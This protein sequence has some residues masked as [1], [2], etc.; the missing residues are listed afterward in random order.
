MKPIVCTAKISSMASKHILLAFGVNRTTRDAMKGEIHWGS[1]LVL[2]A[3]PFAVSRARQVFVHVSFLQ[4][5]IIAKPW[6]LSTKCSGVS[7]F[8]LFEGSAVLAWLTPCTKRKF[9]NMW[10][11]RN[12]VPHLPL[13]IY[14]RLLAC[15]CCALWQLLK[16][17]YIPVQSCWLGFWLV[18]VFLLITPYKSS[19]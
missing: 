17:W 12:L 11:L 7:H 8:S 13:Q 5:S 9:C 18:R 19:I 3:T 1:D 10:P 6:K 2:Q 15:S 16:G 4:R 14:I